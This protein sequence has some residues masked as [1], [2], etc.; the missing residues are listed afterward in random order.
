M[1]G[2]LSKAFL[3][4]ND[5][6]LIIIQEEEKPSI[7]VTDIYYEGKDDRRNDEREEGLEGTEKAVV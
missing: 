2:F 5:G 3:H 4:S 6:S 7:R 1:S